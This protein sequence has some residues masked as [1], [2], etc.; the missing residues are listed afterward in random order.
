MLERPA[1]F[2]AINLVYC[3]HPCHYLGKGFKETRDE[4]KLGKGFRKIRDENK[5]TA[6]LGLAGS[7]NQK[8]DKFS[9]VCYIK[10]EGK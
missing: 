1:F 9:Q 4:N 8:L 2:Y 6:E 7:K 3:Y 10:K 5:G